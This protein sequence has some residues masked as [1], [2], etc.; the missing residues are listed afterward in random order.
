MKESEKAEIVEWMT[1]FE[2]NHYM[3]T[4]ARKAIVWAKRYWR[5]GI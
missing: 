2:A 3:G 1:W 5:S 4:N